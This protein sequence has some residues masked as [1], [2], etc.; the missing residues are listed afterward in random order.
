M[1]D[2]DS[3]RNAEVKLKIVAGN[4]DE[5]FRID[6]VSGILFV[7][8]KLDAETK[9]RYTLTVSAVDGGNVGSQKQSSAR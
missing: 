4:R 1:S 6:P 8:G 2:E 7:A 9:A 5:Q 3:G